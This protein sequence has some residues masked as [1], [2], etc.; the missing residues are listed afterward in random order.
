MGD[1]KATKVG[2]E[3]LIRFIDGETDLLMFRHSA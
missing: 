2:S 3:I 1:K